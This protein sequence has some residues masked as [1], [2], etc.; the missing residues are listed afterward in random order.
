MDRRRFVGALAG[1]VLATPQMARAQQAPK[2]PLIAALSAGSPL[3]AGTGSFDAFLTRL[4]A[5]LA[6]AMHLTCAFRAGTMLVVVV[7]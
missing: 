3:P 7:T 4:K 5:S 2:L 6:D 1:G